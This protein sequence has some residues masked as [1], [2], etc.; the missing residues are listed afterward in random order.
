MRLRLL[1]AFVLLGLMSTQR[2]WCETKP[3]FSGIW[4]LDTVESSY[5]NKASMPSRLTWSIRHD[6]A[7][8][9]FDIEQVLNGKTSNDNV[10][11]VIGDRTSTAPAVAEWKGSA[12][13]LTLVHKDG[14]KRMET[15][16]LSA[17]R[18]KLVDEVVV[19]KRDGSESKLH[20]VFEKQ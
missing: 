17:D 4:N 7:D 3:N 14:S 19:R 18:R 6:G 5:P 16:T 13:S 10:D 15:W 20:L 11:V 1:V 8:F 2:G 9:T 12:L